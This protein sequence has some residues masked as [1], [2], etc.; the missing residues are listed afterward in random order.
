MGPS[1][2]SGT[3]IPANKRP[4][5]KGK[6]PGGGTA[7]AGGTNFQAAITAI[8]SVHLL[9][10]K[11]LGWLT[12]LVDDIPVGIWAESEGPGDDLRLELVDG[13]VA[14]VQAKKGLQR[15]AALWEALDALAAAVSRGRLDFGVLIFT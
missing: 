9:A 3:S 13:R 14:E 1:K 8:A 10:G 5:P 12:G 2:K 7:A 11:P 6:K 4:L 15:G